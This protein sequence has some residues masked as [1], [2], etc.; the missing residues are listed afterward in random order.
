[1][2]ASRVSRYLNAVFN[3]VGMDYR[4][5]SAPE[6]ELTFCKIP[7]SALFWGMVLPMLLSQ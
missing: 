7:S 2:C 6:V 5:N 1:M 3:P 4:T